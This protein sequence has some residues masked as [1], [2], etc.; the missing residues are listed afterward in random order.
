MSRA[1]V[2]GGAGFVGR[3]IVRALAEGGHEVHVAE[4]HGAAVEGAAK[5]HPV[6]LLAPG[7]ARAVV[8]T[9]KPSHLVHA[10][11]YAKP[12]LYWTSDLNLAWAEASLALA[13]AFADVGGEH[14]IGL[15]SCAEYAWDHGVCR[16]DDTPLVPAT[17]YGAT[18]DGVRRVLAAFGAQRG[19]RVAWARLFFL[20]GPHEAAGRLVSSVCQ[21]LVRGEATRCAS[22]TPVR[23]FIH[24]EDAARAVAAL[25]SAS[26][27]G[28]FNIGSGE[29][30]TLR[31]I[32]ERLATAA[33]RPELAR[34][35]DLPD[36]AGDPPLLVPDVTRLQALGF[37]LRFDL[38]SGL[39]ATMAWWREHEASGS[40]GS[41]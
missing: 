1:L 34:F 12:G 15:G 13:R 10:A 4:L 23:D 32:V 11:W 24:V 28:A 36:R 29:R 35:G 25:V 38:A 18:K 16:E 37:R 40:R 5:V 30:T 2:T 19:F 39:D 31:G 22:G 8:E 41:R 26:A 3:A 6:D 20:Y 14:L 9:V 17:L 21:S 33:G 27:T 7:A